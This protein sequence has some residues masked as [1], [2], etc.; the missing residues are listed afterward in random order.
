MLML[1]S[2]LNPQDVSCL[3][4]VL[5]VPHRGGPRRSGARRCFWRP[6]MRADIL[7]GSAA[8]AGQGPQPDCEGAGARRLY[9]AKGI[10]AGRAGSV[11]RVEVK[12]PLCRWPLARQGKREGSWPFN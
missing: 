11:G 4:F 2:S 8:G 7:C 12:A 1:V 6:C 3:A 10:M 5:Q 9:A